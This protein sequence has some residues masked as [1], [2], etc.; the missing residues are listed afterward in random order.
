MTS[1]FL[2]ELLG[3]MVLIILGNGVVAGALLRGSKAEGA[4]WIAITAGWA[5][6]VLAGIFVATATGSP[7]AHIN[8]A[9]MIAGAI[10]SG[11]PSKLLIYV[12]A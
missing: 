10:T 11:K 2:G 9:V 8:P 1:P 4:G 12:P 5:F 7:D 6:A 3:T